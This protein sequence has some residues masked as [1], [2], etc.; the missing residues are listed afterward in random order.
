M[1]CACVCVCL[2]VCVCVCVLRTQ[3][4]LE[5]LRRDPVVLYVTSTKTEEIGPRVFR[6][7]ADVAWNADKLVERYGERVGRQAV[8]ERLQAAL[9]ADR[10]AAVRATNGASGG[11]ASGGVG[12][13]VGQQPSELDKVLKAYGREIISAV[14]AEVD[15][16]EL[17][18]QVSTCVCVCVRMHA[19][20]RTFVTP[21]SGQ[22]DCSFSCTAQLSGLTSEL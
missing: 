17:E 15:R 2:C 5:H 18:L 13:G 16:I 3:E 20:K 7:T 8:V 4:V 21:P 6:F 11:C 14:G 10:I 9:D 22:Q 1:T 12:N 19:L